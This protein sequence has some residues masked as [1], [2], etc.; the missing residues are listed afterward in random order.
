[1]RLMYPESKT[2]AVW[3]PKA[4]DL[5]YW[6]KMSVDTWAHYFTHRASCMKVSQNRNI[7]FQQIFFLLQGCAIS[8]SLRAIF[9]MLHNKFQRHKVP[10]GIGMENPL[11][12][13]I[14][15]N[16][17]FSITSKSG[18]NEENQPSHKNN[19]L[20][21]ILKSKICLKILCLSFFSN[22]YVCFTC[23]LYLIF[24]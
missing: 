2:A 11:S 21:L 19:L 20:S 24:Y 10:Y 9:E 5:C 17:I 7:S 6:R 16:H 22:V 13:P 15:S 14:T 3:T 4:C 8:L 12:I 18:L 23:T 1:M